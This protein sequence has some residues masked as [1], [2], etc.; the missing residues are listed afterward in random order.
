MATSLLIK[1]V[2]IFDG[3]NEIPCG[4]VLVEDGVI[5]QVSRDQL[6]VSDTSTIVLSKPGHTLIPG[7]VDGHAHPDIDEENTALKQ[8]LKFGITTLCD[9]HQEA[10]NIGTLRALARDPDA[11]DLKTSSA[12]ATIRGG[13]PA[14]VITA[15]DKSEETR[16][17]IA[18]WPDLK[19]QADVDAFIQARIKDKA[20]Y[21]KLMH[22]DGNGLIVK[23]PL[24]PL[25]L[26][27]A[28]IDAAHQHG[29]LTVAHALSLQG[30]ID[31]LRAGVD[32]LT[33]TF[34]DKPPTKEVID[35]Y[36]A[37]NAHCN[38]TLAAIGSL[39]TEGQK[40]QERYAHDPRVQKL[41]GAGGTQHLCACMAL[42]NG[43]ASVE[44]AY[45]SVREL[46]AAGI[47][48]ILGSDSAGPALG[49][50]F[51]ASAHHELATLVKKCGFTPK[52]ALRAGTSLISKRLRFSDRGRIAEGLRA[53]LVLVDGNPLEDIDN[54]LNLRG[55]WKRGIL[56][57]TY[58]DLLA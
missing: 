57:S 44:Y 49:T 45:Q 6:G 30:T 58:R 46:K 13:W 56:C 5:K 21:I 3:E 24:P 39:T 9:M 11:A 47:D 52:E 26:Q 7:I 50:A 54:T 55:V 36:L 15:L 1:D 14:A 10:E 31:I 33:H 40:E 37:N 41:L 18:T 38:P 19:T 43:D 22:E 34:F 25:E 8:A 51:G 29:L 12:S 27:K 28:L 20:D 42:A 23:P 53:D 4:S 48:I 2:R 16:A 17:K 32:G 35:A